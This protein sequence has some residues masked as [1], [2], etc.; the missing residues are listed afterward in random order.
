MRFQAFSFSL[1]SSSSLRLRSRSV[2]SSM[3]VA[4]WGNSFERISGLEAV[5]SAK[6][7][8]KKKKNNF[9]VL[10]QLCL[11][12]FSHS[13]FVEDCEKL[14]RLAGSIILARKVL[15]DDSRRVPSEELVKC[16]GTGFDRLIKLILRLES[17]PDSRCRTKRLR[18]TGKTVIFSVSCVSTLL[19]IYFNGDTPL[20]TLDTGRIVYSS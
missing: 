8:S 5:F 10:S 13:L 18:E 12:S 11:L 1:A 4:V 6:P 2:S 17:G 15:W 7:Q 9:I 16:P 14:R 20:E 19:L 3:L